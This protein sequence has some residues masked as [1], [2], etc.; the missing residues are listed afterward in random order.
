M[1]PSPSSAASSLERTVSRRRCLGSG[2]GVGLGL[3]LALGQGLG[4]GLRVGLGLG[5]GL[6]LG[7][8]QA[9]V[10]LGAPTQRG[11]HSRAERAE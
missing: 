7:F 5:L 3:G 9:E 10:P 11:R 1:P 4:L 8:E 2:L 6:G